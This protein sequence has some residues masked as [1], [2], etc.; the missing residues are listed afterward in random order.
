MTVGAVSLYQYSSN[1]NYDT[2]DQ[3]KFFN[4]VVSDERLQQLMER[5]GIIQTGDSYND[6][7][8]LYLAMYPEAVAD[9]TAAQASSGSKQAQPAQQASQAAAAQ[10]S[11]NVPWAN[12]MSQIGLSA[13]GSFERDYNEFNQRISLMQINAFSPQDKAMVAQLQAQARVVFVQQSAQAQSSQA[14]TNSQ[15]QQASGADIMAQLNK[16]Y[17]VG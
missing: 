15:P 17:S 7:H 8:A 16:L 10:S 4:T 2:T 11:N 5:Y 9:A 14:Q 13:T 12:L 6:L 1:Y 3:Y